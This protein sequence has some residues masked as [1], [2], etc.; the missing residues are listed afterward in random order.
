MLRCEERRRGGGGEVKRGSRVELPRHSF[1]YT[2]TAISDIVSIGR[3]VHPLDEL[4]Q[5]RY[6][7]GWD[8]GAELETERRTL[9]CVSLIDLRE[10]PVRG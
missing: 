2:A 1:C 6:G 3:L 9:L 7:L 10:H 8:E 5:F 4:L